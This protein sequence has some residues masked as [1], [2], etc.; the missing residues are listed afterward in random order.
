VAGDRAFLD[1]WFGFADAPQVG[2]PLLGERIWQRARDALQ[3]GEHMLVVFNDGTTS[4]KG[5]GFVRGGIFDRFRLEQGLSGQTFRDLD[6][7]TLQPPPVADAP[8]F[9]EGG[10]FLTRNGSIDPGEPLDMVF[11]A[12]EYDTSKGAFNR[13]FKSFDAAW[14]APRSV[15]RTVG[16]APAWQM[17]QD[18]WTLAPVRT[19]LVTLWL[20]LAVALFAGRRWLTA[21]LARLKKIHIG[22]M[23][24]SFV[25]LGL[26]LG[27]QPSVT[28]VLT[29]VGAVV[30]EWRWSLFLSDPVVFLTWLFLLGVMFTWGRGVFCG[31]AC[32]YGSMT[33]LA[34][35]LREKVGLPEYIVPDRFHR[36]LR[37]GRYLVLFGLVAAYL[38]DAELGERMAEIEPFKSTFYVPPWTRHPGLFA[39]WGV[40][41]GASFFTWRPFCQYMC[42]LGAT[43][44]IPSYFRFSGPRRRDFCTSCKIC[45]RTCEPRAID[46]NGVINGADCLNCMECEANYRSDEICPPLVKVRRDAERATA[47]HPPA[48]LG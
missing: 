25:G 48:D 43:F 9:R 15:Y 10:L 17:V 38:F 22:Y 14:Q 7:T 40:L 39:W 16:L 23:A 37:Y 46:A 13:D 20:L 28:Q 30:G 47:A 8:R 21:D 4:F 5:S 24:G 44:A 45:T 12:S 27:V 1:L 34:F 36:P 32:P 41:L 31:W 42:P 33:E 3:P 11:L 29:G 35:K 18:A 2:I 26:V 6:Y 19:A